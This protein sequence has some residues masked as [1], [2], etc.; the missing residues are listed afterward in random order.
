MKLISI[1]L[2]SNKP[3]HFRR[4]VENLVATAADPTC[5]EVV[6]KIDIGDQA[7]SAAIAK[8]RNDINVNLK[9]VI[10]ERPASYFHT[11]IACNEAY[12]VSD[13]EYYFCW[14]LNDEVLIETKHWDVKLARFIGF[15]PD[16]IFRLKV[17]PR[18]MF[19][20]FFD[21]HEVC[22]FADYPIVPRKWLEITGGWAECHGPD[23][24]QEG[25][26]IYLA[27]YGYHRNVPF[28]DILVGGDEAGENLS[29]EKSLARAQGACIAWDYSLTARMQETYARTA[30]RLQLAIIA[31]EL[32]LPAYELRDDANWKSITL[33]HDNRA[34]SRQFYS[35]DYVGVSLSH[36]S[37]I[38]L[39]KWPYSLWGKSLPFRT[40]AY[41]Y[42][43]LHAVSVA[44]V[45]IAKIPI[46]MLLGFKLRAMLGSLMETRYSH[47]RYPKDKL[48]RDLKIRISRLTASYNRTAAK[49]ALVL[50]KRAAPTYKISKPP[51]HWRLRACLATHLPRTAAIYRRL[52]ALIRR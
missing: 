42:R 23:T 30:R 28:F 40:S 52:R 9:V 29:P 26:A 13:P 10:S 16:H 2:P 15:F 5:F 39:R 7:M 45:G 43:G 44:V 11:Y 8:I 49:L 25:I 4:L 31:H 47:Y 24:Y 3:F 33:V 19:F 21:I 14:H 35:I 34:I 36:F 12:L 50:P 41:A 17:N 1:H 20:N 38:A 32:K 22:L 6:V 51:W 46:G 48:I 27:K 37:Y 18:K